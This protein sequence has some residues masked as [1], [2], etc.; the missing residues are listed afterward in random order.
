[1]A[2][3][4]DIPGLLSEMIAGAGLICTAYFTARIAVDA[5]RLLRRAVDGGVDEPDDEGLENPL[6]WEETLDLVRTY[7]PEFAI[8]QLVAAGMSHDAAVEEAMS[9]DYEIQ[10]YE[11]NE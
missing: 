1:M 7:G 11:R 3:P 8:G 9:A 4:G 2:L 10:C 5:I 6:S